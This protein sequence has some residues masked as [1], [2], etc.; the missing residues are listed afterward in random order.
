MQLN[1]INQQFNLEGE[2]HINK[3]LLF[4]DIG[5]RQVSARRADQ[6]GGEESAYKV[7]VLF[8]TL[9]THGRGFQSADRRCGTGL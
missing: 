8:E 5:E 7:R 9:Y 4:V 1:L 2:K 6:E 3:L